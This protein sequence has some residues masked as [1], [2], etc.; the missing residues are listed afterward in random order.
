MGY[1]SYKD[2]V[3]RALDEAKKNA[4]ETIGA[5]VV[6]EAKLRTP[7][8]SGNLKRSETFEVM[9]KNEGVMVGST[10]N[11]PYDIWVEKGTAKQKAQP[12][13]EPAVMDNISK[14]EELTGY[15]IKEKMSGD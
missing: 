12:H 13:W 5:F 9:N 6:A 8:L 2:N 7:V 11:A 1:K 10:P 4:C 14:I 3:I 15:T